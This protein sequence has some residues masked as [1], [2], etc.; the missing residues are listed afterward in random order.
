MQNNCVI[1][2]DKTC[3]NKNDGKSECTSE[4]LKEKFKDK[5]YII[6]SDCKECTCAK[7]S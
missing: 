7:C 6:I 1:H 4:T 2:C 5:S 3:C